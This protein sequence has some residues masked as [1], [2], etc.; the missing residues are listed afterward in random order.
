[1]VGHAD[2]TLFDQQL[3]NATLTKQ[4]TQRALDKA[5]AQIQARLARWFGGFLMTVLTGG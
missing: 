1:M 3:Q 5:N 4:E 2:R